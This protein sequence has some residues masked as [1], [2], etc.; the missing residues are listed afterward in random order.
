MSGDLKLGRFIYSITYFRQL[1]QENSR[2]LNIKALPILGFSIR[3]TRFLINSEAAYSFSQ[4][5]GRK[6]GCFVA[7]PMRGRFRSVP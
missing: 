3:F 2:S 5:D 1:L 4:N 7:V 6:A